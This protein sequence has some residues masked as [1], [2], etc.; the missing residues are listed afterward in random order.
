MKKT[1]KKQK[2]GR[3][4]SLEFSQLRETSPWTQS[5]VEHR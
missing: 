1:K 3:E 4:N 2:R 5:I